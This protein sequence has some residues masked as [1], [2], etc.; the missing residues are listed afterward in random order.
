MAVTQR[1]LQGVALNCRTI[2]N[3]CNLKLALETGRDASHKVCHHRAGH[4]PL[5]A[6]ALGGAARRDSHNITVNGNRDVVGCMEAFGPLGA[7]NFNGLAGHGRRNACGQLDRF[8]TNT[9]HCLPP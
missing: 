4:A 6:R 9:R 5:L 1:Q 3:T 7:F 8:L 2:T